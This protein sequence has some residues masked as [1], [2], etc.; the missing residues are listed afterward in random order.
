MIDPAIT[1]PARL[2]DIGGQ[3]EGPRGAERDEH[4]DSNPLGIPQEQDGPAQ[5][6]GGGRDWVLHESRE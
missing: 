5:D 1:L 4:L 2:L 3:G 6:G